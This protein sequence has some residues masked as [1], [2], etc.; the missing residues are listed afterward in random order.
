MKKWK[1]KKGKCIIV[2]KSHKFPTPKGRISY[3]D[4]LSIGDKLNTI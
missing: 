2:S 3:L 4:G 1:T